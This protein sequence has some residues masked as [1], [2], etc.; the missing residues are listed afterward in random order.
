MAHICAIGTVAAMVGS[1]RIVPVVSI[2]H[3]TGDPRL[4]PEMEK[5]IRREVVEKALK[6]LTRENRYTGEGKG[7]KAG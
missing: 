7:Y 4:E 1:T 5:R 2:V 6:S 3:P